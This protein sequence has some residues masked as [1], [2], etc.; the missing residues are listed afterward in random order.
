[1]NFRNIQFNPSH[2]LSGLRP[3]L[4]L[5]IALWLLGSF[6][7]GW[8]VNSFLI[9]LGLLSITPVIL[10]FGFRW[11][12]QGN[13]V[14]GCCPVCGNEVTG[15]NNTQLQCNSCGEKLLIREKQI[16]RFSAE[17]TIDVEVTEVSY[18]SPEDS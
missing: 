14:G 2:L 7:L 18:N 5:F 3:W 1:M 15:L 9:L 16:Q 11:W 4:N 8:L 6:G 12:L 10:F 17:G 13:L